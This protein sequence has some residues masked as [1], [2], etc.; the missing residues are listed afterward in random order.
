M[1]RRPILALC[2]ATLAVLIA[3]SAALAA[4]GPKVTV[5]I[6]GRTHTLLAPTTAQTHTG[7][8]RKGGAPA[9]ACPATSAAGALDVASH[10]HWSG[11]FDS[12]IGDYFITTILGDTESGT[13]SFWGIWVDNRFATTG[14]C[15]IKLRRGDRV[16][17][18]VAPATGT[19]YPTALS[20]PRHATAGHAF[21]VK[22]V[23]FN[24]RGKAEPLKGA[25]IAGQGVGSA[26]TNKHGT[27]TITGDRA[28]ALVLGASEPGY[29]RAATVRVRVA[30]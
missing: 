27:A 7:F 6:E 25:R 22:V 28:G 11:K 5:R 2:G 8:V 19:V 3:P 24:A 4:G 12:G 21:I 29:I 20:A 26:V 14:A 13:H 10:H 15:G 16:L 9:G 1:H 30:G 18:A 23:Y 17:F